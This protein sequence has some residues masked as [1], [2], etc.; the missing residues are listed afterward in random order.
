MISWKA[1]LVGA[2]NALVSGLASGVAGG[3][4]GV[5]FKHAIEIAG[6][7]AIV[8]LAKWVLQHPLPGTPA[9]AVTK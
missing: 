3:L 6:V 9:P 4:L 5:G 8:S 7:S 2:A 1:W